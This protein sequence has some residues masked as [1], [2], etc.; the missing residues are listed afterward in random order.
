MQD[1]IKSNDELLAEVAQL[2]QRITEFEAKERSGASRRRL[3]DR[4]GAV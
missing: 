1:N 3:Y 2:R 4:A